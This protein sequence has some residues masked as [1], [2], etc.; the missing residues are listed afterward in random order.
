MKQKQLLGRPLSVF[1]TVPAYLSAFSV[2]TSPRT[3]SSG[4]AALGF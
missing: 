3:A 4:R 2:L 1:S